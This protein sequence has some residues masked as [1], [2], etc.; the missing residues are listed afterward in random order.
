MAEPK[1]PLEG[2]REQALAAMR[3]APGK[4]TQ[5]GNGGPLGPQEA[6]QRANL[7]HMARLAADFLDQIG[8]DADDAARLYRSECQRLAE[9][10]RN[11][12]DQ[13]LARLIG[14]RK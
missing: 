12:T 11:L 6:G 7:H 9:E 3:Q 14:L 2:Q 10:Y 4:P 1:S 5:A 13:F 8:T